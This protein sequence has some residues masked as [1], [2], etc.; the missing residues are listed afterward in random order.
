MYGA[1]RK[2]F[3]RGHYQGENSISPVLL[4]EMIKLKL[5]EKSIS[6][7]VRKN[8]SILRREEDIEQSIAQLEREIENHQITEETKKHLQ[9]RLDAQKEELEKIIEY[10]TQGAIKRAKVRWYNEGEKNTSYFLSL[11]KRHCRQ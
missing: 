2:F 6:Y 1:V 5:R 9:T 7:A 8:K 10:R 11:E 3:P 4:W